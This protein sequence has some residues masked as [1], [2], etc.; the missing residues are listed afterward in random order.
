[1]YTGESYGL[2][3]VDPGEQELI[4][5]QLTIVPREVDYPNVGMP[6]SFTWKVPEPQEHSIPLSELD[7]LG[8]N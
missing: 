7:G 4:D 2:E 8:I 3:S 1:M 5:S 6:E